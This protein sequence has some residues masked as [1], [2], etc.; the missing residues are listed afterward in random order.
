M[1]ERLAK[2][3]YSVTKAASGREAID[4]AKENLPNLI[5]LDIAMPGMDGSET[6]AILRK[7]SITKNV[8]IL[9]LT[10]LFTKKN[11]IA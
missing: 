11:L 6:A 10:C 8:P 5:I 2:A 9:F 4:A 7:E 3:G 1:G